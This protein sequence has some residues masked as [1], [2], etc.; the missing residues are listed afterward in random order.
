MT[1]VDRVDDHQTCLIVREAARY[2]NDLERT[3]TEWGPKSPEHLLDETWTVKHRATLDSSED[4]LTEMTFTL[5]WGHF[6]VLRL[7]YW[8][9]SSLNRLAKDVDYS[10]LHWEESLRVN[11]HQRCRGDY[12][13]NSDLACSNL[14]E[15]DRER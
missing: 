11:E 14:G 6:D 10:R 15:Y 8:K 13:R 12:Y 9:P 3:L 5:R 7:K 4:K 1:N 2:I